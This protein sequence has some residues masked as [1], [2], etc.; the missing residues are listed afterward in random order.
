VPYVVGVASNSILLTTERS[1]MDF[2]AMRPGRK[3][4]KV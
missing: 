4:K 2:L 1:E 3:K